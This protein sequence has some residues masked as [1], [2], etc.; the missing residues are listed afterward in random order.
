MELFGNFF[1]AEPLGVTAHQAIA[2][3]L[4]DLSKVTRWRDDLCVGIA[5]KGTQSW[6]VSAHRCS[7]L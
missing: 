1:Q 4:S 2:D 7:Q 3:V 5:Q 6:L